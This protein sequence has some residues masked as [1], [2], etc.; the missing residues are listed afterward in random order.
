MKKILKYINVFYKGSLGIFVEIFYV[1]LIFILSLVLNFIF[2][3]F[4]KLL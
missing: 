3:F 1:I 2:Y 4:I